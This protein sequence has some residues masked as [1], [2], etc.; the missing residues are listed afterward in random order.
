MRPNKGGGT[1]QY[2]VHGLCPIPFFLYAFA[3]S[4]V[5]VSSLEV[6]LCLSTLGHESNPLSHHHVQIGVYKRI[7]DG[8]SLGRTQ[9]NILC[10]P[11]CCSGESKLSSSLLEFTWVLSSFLVLLRSQTFEFPLE[12]VDFISLMDVGIETVIVLL[13][14]ID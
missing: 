5:S 12:G 2:S 4:G 14:E 7:F 8:F 3:P 6:L 13:V 10:S 9:A 1:H 11:A